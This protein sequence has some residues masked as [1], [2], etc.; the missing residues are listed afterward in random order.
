[1]KIKVT[2]STMPEM[3]PPGEYDIRCVDTTLGMDGRQMDLKGVRGVGSWTPK[4]AR[5]PMFRTRYMVSLS[6]CSTPCLITF[7]GKLAERRRAQLDRLCMQLLKIGGQALSVQMKS[8]PGQVPEE[9]C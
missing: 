5:R 4:K 9:A 6:S 7:D 8:E 1:M 3:M 2:E